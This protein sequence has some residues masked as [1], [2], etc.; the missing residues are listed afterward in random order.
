M[1]PARTHDQSANRSTLRTSVAYRLLGA[2]MA[3]LPLS[4]S[5]SL[6]LASHAQTAD[7]A[8][9]GATQPAVI[10]NISAPS[11]PQD[12]VFL[13]AR[14]AAKRKDF[15]KL[16]Q[17]ADQLG[18][19]PLQLW[20][21]QWRWRA[22]L[23]D[24]RY[25]GSRDA[26]VRDLLN[27]YPLQASTDLIRRDYLTSL[28][29]RK[30]GAGFDAE[31]A[32]AP[33][34]DDAQIQ[35]FAARQQVLRGDDANQG[36]KTL[37]R[38]KELGDGCVALAEQ[39]AEAGKL[40]ARDLLDRI[41]AATEMNALGSARSLSALMPSAAAALQAAIGTPDKVLAQGIDGAASQEAAVLAIIRVARET[42]HD[43][44]R[45]LQKIAGQLT[46][47]QRS[48]AWLQI[49]QAAA[50]K[51]I[52]DAAGWAAQAEDP[53]TRITD[54]G[55]GWVIRAALRERQYPLVLA[56]YQRMTEDGQ[57][58]PTWTYW[59]GR[60]HAEAG[61]QEQARTLYTRISDGWDFYHLMAR[62]ELGLPLAV[63]APSTPA[64]VDEVLA[65]ARQESVRRAWHLLSLGVRP[66]GVWEFNANLKGLNDRQL[67]A[68]AEAGKRA[69]F[70]DRMISAADRTKQEH[71]FTMR[72]PRP[73]REVLTPAAHREGLSS[74]W[75]YGLIRQES[76]FVTNARSVVGASGLM[77]LM[78]A[79]A[80]Q[81]AK[82]LGL[83]PAAATQV[84]DP[85]MNAKLGTAYLRSVADQLDQ[86]PM[87]A[88]AAYNAGPGRPKNWR[89]NLAQRIEGAAF[90]ESI[91]FHET[92]D[93]VK[94]VIANAA[95]YA[96]THEGK[97]LSI[98]KL[99]GDVGPD[100]AQGLKAL[101][102]S[103]GQ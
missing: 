1:R 5:L 68:A 87:L 17:L 23:L 100:G 34:P 46:R 56:T 45:K 42:P 75:V 64:S 20:V 50:R 7:P 4:L 88:S 32:R 26:E 59:A 95:L 2:C 92:R 11:H 10:A 80:R 67:L 40:N 12:P 54:D 13:A 96:A 98:R 65:F 66:E 61:R 41:R 81:V 86:S 74:H 3:A 102:C 97:S 77:Q 90:A 31:A 91:P 16:D 38:A 82:Q 53:Q 94:R 85:T 70:L 21:E 36:L 72:Y 48:V 62:D 18:D 57:R 14:D 93:Y 78:P 44:A 73:L 49:S 37:M 55:L 19:H 47:E 28:L 99:M 52:P 25:D 60:A 101:C 83:D 89:A 6:P 24:R 22:R 27:R 79:T 8:G 43:A 103:V 76:R 58:D 29:R 71:D 15:A 30:D 63:P 33:L 39:L 69:G 51:L 35:C 9:T 84:D